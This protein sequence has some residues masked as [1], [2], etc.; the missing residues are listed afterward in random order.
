ML[1]KT[2]YTR[3]YVIPGEFQSLYS[4]NA[5]S[6]NGWIFYSLWIGCTFYWRAS[7][8]WKIKFEMLVW[9]EIVTFMK[10]FC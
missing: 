9:A 3:Q 7:F 1:N 8:V 2:Y 4:R 6:K 10:G 5:L